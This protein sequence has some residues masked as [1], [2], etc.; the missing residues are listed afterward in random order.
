MVF[1]KKLFL[2]VVKFAS[3]T[4]GESA[5]RVDDLFL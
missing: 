3:K 1:E 2:N 4:R 5:D